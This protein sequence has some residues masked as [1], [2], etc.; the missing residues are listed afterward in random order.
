MWAWV[1]HDP[2]ARSITWKPPPKALAH[3]VTV[4][5]TML[6]MVA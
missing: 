1:D 3:V 4:E 6:A 5:A 2:A